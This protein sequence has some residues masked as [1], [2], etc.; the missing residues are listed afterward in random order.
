MNKNSVKYFNSLG[1]KF[2][3]GYRVKKNVVEAMKN[4]KK[5]SDLGDPH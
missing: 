1:N 5:S 4:C 3:K 2:L